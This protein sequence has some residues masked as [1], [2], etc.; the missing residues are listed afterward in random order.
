MACSLVLNELFQEE[1]R[2]PLALS[3]HSIPGAS[4]LSTAAARGEVLM[5]N[6]CEGGG[7]DFPR[8]QPG[9]ELEMSDMRKNSHSV[10]PS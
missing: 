10:Y 4:T 8:H 5:E 3:P 2:C 7:F 1:P 6:L 9:C